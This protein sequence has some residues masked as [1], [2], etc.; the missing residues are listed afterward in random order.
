MIL[1]HVTSADAL[2]GKGGS[3]AASRDARRAAG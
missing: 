3:P 1:Y 2:V